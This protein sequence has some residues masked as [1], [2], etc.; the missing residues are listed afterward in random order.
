[1]NYISM[2]AHYDR[3]D[4]GSTLVRFVHNDFIQILYEN[5]IIGLIGFPAFG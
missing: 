5:G 1:M 2:K 4:N 3:T